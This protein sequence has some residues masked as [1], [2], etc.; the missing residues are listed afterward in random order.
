MKK[1]EEHATQDEQ[2][3]LSTL[4]E[5]LSTRQLKMQLVMRKVQL[6]DDFKMTTQTQNEMNLNIDCD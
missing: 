1:Q 2:Q 3:K 4:L 6:T 5:L